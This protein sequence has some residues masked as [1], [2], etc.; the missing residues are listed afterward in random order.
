MINIYLL[1]KRNVA[2]IVSTTWI[3]NYLFVQFFTCNVIRFLSFCTKLTSDKSLIV[4]KI[5]MKYII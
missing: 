4:T 1:C 2:R 5:D 3:F